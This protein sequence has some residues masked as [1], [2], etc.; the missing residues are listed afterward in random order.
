MDPE[1]L[2][3]EPCERVVPA[4]LEVAIGLPADREQPVVGEVDDGAAGEELGQKRVVRPAAEGAAH[5]TS[6]TPDFFEALGRD[7]L[8]LE[9]EFNRRA[10]FTER[11]DELPAFFY[12]EPLPPT[13]QTARFHAGDV[14]RI[15]ERLTT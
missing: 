2:E 6:L 1:A 15:Y 7:T 13:N 3:L 12:E 5:G 9:A 8:R 4:L 14:H 11:D 10:G